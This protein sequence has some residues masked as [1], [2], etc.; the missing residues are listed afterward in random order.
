MEISSDDSGPTHVLSPRLL[1]MTIQYSYD[2][3]WSRELIFKAGASHLS[4][5]G[6]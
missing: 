2:A 4:E 1:F 3:F 6:S 5:L